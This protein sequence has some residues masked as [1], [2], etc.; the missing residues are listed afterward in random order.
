[1]K[2]Q[3]SSGSIFIPDN[4]EE[5]AA[6]ART[7][8]LAISAHQDDI[9]LMA[10]HGILECFG[11]EDAWFTGVVTA[12]GAGSPRDSIYANY[13]DEDMKRVRALEQRKAAFVGEYSAMLQLGY[14]SQSIKSPSERA[15]VEE[16]VEI[17]RATRPKYVYTHN[18]AD[19]HDTHCGVV[20]KVIQALRK[21]KEDER[22]ERVFGCEV[23]RDLDWLNDEC[24]VIFDLS[25]H[26][27]I[28][29]SLVGVF[30]SQICGGKRY[31]LAASGR[32]TANAT[33][34]SSHG[35]DSASS[36]G[37]AMDLTPLIKD[38]SI[39][40]LDYVLGYIDA[41]KADVKNRLTAV[42]GLI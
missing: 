18:L 8:H 25:A 6:L 10:Y 4:C 5:R 32:R 33:Y 12:D 38:D 37:Y 30:D 3:N 34:S 40:V 16:Y 41:F 9:E 21:L 29:M 13:S 23:W 42:R 1:M 14:S 19:K 15:V 31:D 17:L 24:K 36:L 11:R 2:F 27:N 22:P 35:C 7:T 20:V 39:D 26:P 28:A